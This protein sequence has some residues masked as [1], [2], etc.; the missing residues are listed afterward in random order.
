MENHGGKIK[1]SA[2]AAV[3]GSMEAVI[4]LYY[5]LGVM[6]KKTIMFPAILCV[7]AL[8]GAATQ[9]QPA[10]VCK[11]GLGSERQAGAETRH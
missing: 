4:G 8:S 3:R 2:C 1:L 6:M 5:L 10:A 7:I 11:R 9:A